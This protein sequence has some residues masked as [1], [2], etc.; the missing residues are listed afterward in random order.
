VYC[1]TI[2]VKMFKIADGCYNYNIMSRY[3]SEVVEVTLATSNFVPCYW[4]LEGLCVLSNNLIRRTYPVEL[5]C[6]MTGQVRFSVYL[7]YVIWD[8][9]ASHHSQSSVV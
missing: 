4:D 1:I 2:E 5:R 3:I 8:V 6:V 7:M 9:L